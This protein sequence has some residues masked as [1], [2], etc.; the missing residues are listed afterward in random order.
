MQVDR[1]T[2]NFEGSRWQDMV[3]MDE[4]ALEAKGVSAQGARRKCESLKS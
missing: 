4:A 3:K 2:P 1:Y